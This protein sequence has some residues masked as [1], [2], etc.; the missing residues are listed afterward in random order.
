TDCGATWTTLYTFNAST[1]TNLTNV[2]TEYSIPIPTLY[3]GQTVQIGFQATDGPIDDTPTYDFH[4]SY[5]QVEEIPGCDTPIF[6]S[7]SNIT[8]NSATINWNA[9]YNGTPNGYQ[10]V[11][12][13]NSTT[14]AGTGTA[15]TGLTANVSSLLP[16]T[17]Y[18]V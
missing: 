17:T 1:T 2:L 14:P 11:V 8:K 15:V 12:S 10:Y 13:A 9:P 4:L 3:N 18:Y 5:I 16:S 6:S 7:F